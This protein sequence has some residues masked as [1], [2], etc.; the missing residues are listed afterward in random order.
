MTRVALTRRWPQT[1]ETL[2]AQ[3]YQL[4][5]SV[6]DGALSTAQLVELAASCDV[7]CPTVTDAVDSSVITAASCKLIANFGAGFAHIDLDAATR[8]GIVVTNTPDVLTDATADLAIT[9]MLMACRRA[10]EGERELREGRW[11]GWRP[12]HL[13]GQ[14]VSGKTL[15]IVGYGRIGAAVARRASAGFGM[16]VLAH[17]RSGKRD[18]HAQAASLSEVLAMSDIVSLHC[19]GGSENRHLI[20]SVELAS[21]KPGSVLINT[22]RGEVVDESALVDALSSGHLAAAGLDVFEQEPTVHPGLLTQARAVLLPHLGSATL[23]TRVAMGM[24]VLANVDDFL[25]GRAPKD[26]V[27]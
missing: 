26:R 10:S 6:D 18:A 14:H 20:G 2:A 13:M 8:Q 16:N 11:Q 22:A 9:L 23:E 1:C 4:M 12:T 15:G 24:R 21:M 17:S 7:F 5:A 3:R 19:P 25:A 27:A